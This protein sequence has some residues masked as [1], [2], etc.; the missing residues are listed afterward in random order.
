M[1]LD[2]PHP[3]PPTAAPCHAF[4]MAS[5][6]VMGGSNFRGNFSM[7]Q[8]HPKRFT[9]DPPQGPVH[10]APADAAPLSR[11]AQGSHPSNPAVAGTD[12]AHHVAG[13]VGQCAAAD[14]GGAGPCHR[15]PFPQSVSGSHP[16][17]QGWV[18]GQRHSGP[19]TPAG[20]T[21]SQ[22]P[23]SGS[24]S[25]SSSGILRDVSN[26][27]N[28]H[29]G[30]N[31][32]LQLKESTPRY[33]NGTATAPA[34][35]GDHQVPWS[36][37]ILRDV[38]NQVSYYHGNG[39][40]MLKEST[41]RHRNGTAAVPAGHGDHQ[42]PWSSSILR[43]VSNQV[44]YYHGNGSSMHLKGSTPLYRNGTAAV[45]AGHGDEHQMSYR[46]HAT[47]PP[48]DLE[49]AEAWGL[50]HL[51]PLRGHH[52][53]DYLACPQT[54]G[55]DG[56]RISGADGSGLVLPRRNHRAPPPR[57]FVTSA[58]DRYVR[59]PSRGNSGGQRRYSAPDQPRPRVLPISGGGRTLSSSSE[60][61]AYGPREAVHCP[62][63]S[64]DR[65][66]SAGVGVSRSDPKGGRQGL[67]G[68]V[69]F[70]SSDGRR[71]TGFEPSTLQGGEL[72][73]SMPDLRRET[74]VLSHNAPAKVSGTGVSLCLSLCL[75]L[76][77]SLSLFVSVCLSVCL[78][79]SRPFL[80]RGRDA[81][82]LGVSLSLSLSVCLSV[83]L[84][85]SV[86]LTHFRS[87]S[88]SLSLIALAHCRFS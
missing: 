74:V 13:N 50:C 42:V 83:C 36:S 14:V 20:R 49:E 51:S 88:L 78:S 61:G 62:R 2:T 38:S 79:F 56:V 82:S 73:T 81:C 72:A 44:S 23:W 35:H 48:A 45:P 39:S 47:S 70:C 43:D 11:G 18:S 77:L 10:C 85:V 52:G 53:R 75:C 27:V 54:P 26:Q 87:L 67:S 21:D 12:S 68:A 34:G 40:S 76:S 22:T 4:T 29:H 66:R 31:T 1:R 7:Y 84:S 37:S 58:S 25:S 19:T 9:P 5:L 64:S 86:S 6:L 71:A 24:S 32:P 33:R 41:P 59:A 80:Y 8:L 63:A 3:P 60:G 69:T 15:Q 28:Y 65:R 30:N 17:T 55:A 16:H 46:G 57:R